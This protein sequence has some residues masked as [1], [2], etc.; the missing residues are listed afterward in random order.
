M[1]R[2]G[3]RS[4]PRAFSSDMSD[5][6]DGVGMSDPTSTYQ[7]DGVVQRRGFPEQEVPAGERKVRVKM[8]CMLD[9]E[10]MKMILGSLDPKIQP[11]KNPVGW[12]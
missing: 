8:A 9:V 5:C 4:I 11:P 12:P 10:A 6:V 1:H 2:N 7:T 3:F